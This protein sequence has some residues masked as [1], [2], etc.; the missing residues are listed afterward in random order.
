MIELTPKKRFLA[1]EE[2]T[3]YF[4]P[5][6]DSPA[7]HHALSTALAEFSMHTAATAEQLD[8]VRAYIRILLNLAEIETSPGQLPVKRLVMHPDTRKSNE[9]QRA[10]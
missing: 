1:N 10:D 8:G 2:A 5:V 3:R 7:F 6:A 9:T 4:R